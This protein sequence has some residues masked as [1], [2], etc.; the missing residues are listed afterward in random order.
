MDPLLGE[1][2]GESQKGGKKSV[3]V[4]GD[5]SRKGRVEGGRAT[6]RRFKIKGVVDEK[7]KGKKREVF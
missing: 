3:G 5:P 4:S 1:K 2:R 6:P 7:Q